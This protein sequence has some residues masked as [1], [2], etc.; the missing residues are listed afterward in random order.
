MVF[1]RRLIARLWICHYLESCG[2]HWSGLFRMFLNFDNT[3]FNSCVTTDKWLKVSYLVW[4][5]IEMKQGWT[6]NLYDGNFLRL[7]IFCYIASHS[8]LL[9]TFSSL[10][11][12]DNI[13]SCLLPSQLM[14]TLLAHS[15]PTSWLQSVRSTMTLFSDFSYPL[16]LP[17]IL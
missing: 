16:W 12:Q 8:L 6:F 17:P 1:T 14:L 10:G 2:E 13:V 5:L 3:F 15:L 4:A 9:E 11:F 7:F